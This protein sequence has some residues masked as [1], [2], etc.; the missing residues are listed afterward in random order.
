M[1]IGNTTRD[2]ELRYTPS[3]AAVASF[4][5]AMNRK[6]KTESGEEKDEVCFVD[7]TAF[8]KSAETLSKYVKKG[9]PL[10]VEGRLKLDQWDDKQSGQKRQKL[11]VIVEGFQFLTFNKDNGEGGGEEGPAQEEKPIQS[12]GSARQQVNRNVRQSQPEPELGE[13]DLPF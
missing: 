2:V 4:G 10:Y 6:W 8:G 1:L 13:D 3:G 5:M 9:N 11:N 12:S 7:C